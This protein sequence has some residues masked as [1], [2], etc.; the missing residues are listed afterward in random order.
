MG[1][2]IE[3]SATSDSDIT[4]GLIALLSEHLSGTDPSTILQA[5]GTEVLDAC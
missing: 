2:T 5:G 3:F 1:G 4:K